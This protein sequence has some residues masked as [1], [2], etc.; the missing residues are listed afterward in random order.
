MAE[1]DGHRLLALVSSALPPALHPCGGIHGLL[2][3]MQRCCIVTATSM[4]HEVRAG[5]KHRRTRGL[6]DTASVLS[7]CTHAAGVDRHVRPCTLNGGYCWRTQKG[8]NLL[9]NRL[10][11][12]FTK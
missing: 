9:A 7:I 12:Q 10:K 11:I 2:S 5:Y 4:I 6:L 3:L 8:R 1:P